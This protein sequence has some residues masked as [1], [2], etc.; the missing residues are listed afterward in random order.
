MTSALQM[1]SWFL[2]G[3]LAALLAVSVWID[4]SP[5]L[6][7]IPPLAWSIPL[8]LAAAI[9][10]AAWPVRGLANGRK[11]AMSPLTAAR[12][13]IFCQACS[14]AGMLLGGIGIGAWIAAAG[15]HAAFLD[16]LASRALWTGLAS[17]LLGG[18]GRLGEWWC[19]ID[20]DEDDPPAAAAGA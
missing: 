13:A 11:S 5:P 1:V 9:L 6:L 4:S 8:I 16:E 17:V 3:L 19:S 10:A 14:R 7:T 20:E 18:A 2:L 12:I 15:N